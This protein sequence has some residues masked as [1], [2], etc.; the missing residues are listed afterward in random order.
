VELE[1]SRKL[2]PLKIRYTIRNR[3]AALCLMMRSRAIRAELGVFEF[4]ERA[5]ALYRRLGHRE[6]NRIPNFTF[7]NGKMWTDIRMG[8]DL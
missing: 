6:F 4:N 8:K 1:I 7:W 3:G 2:N 5:Q